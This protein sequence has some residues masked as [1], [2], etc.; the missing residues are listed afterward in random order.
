[1][2]QKI[3]RA[4]YSVLSLPFLLGFLNISFQLR[5]TGYRNS[6][7]YSYYFFQKKEHFQ[8][9]IAF[10]SK[11]KFCNMLLFSWDSVWI[12]WKFS[13][14]EINA[15]WLYWL[16]LDFSYYSLPALQSY[17]AFIENIHSSRRRF[18]DLRWTRHC[19]HRTGHWCEWRGNRPVHFRY[20]SV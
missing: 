4:F 20:L 13:F 15:C 7:R 12:W 11:K 17:E 6:H 1:M 10:T 19:S 18:L 16:P 3:W 5:E 8:S 2:L 14:V 9:G